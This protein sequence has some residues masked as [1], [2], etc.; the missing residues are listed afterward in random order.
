M[1]ASLALQFSLAIITALVTVSPLSASPECSDS[2]VRHMATHG[3]TVAA[4]GE[5]CAMDEDDVLYIIEA[6]TESDIG[7]KLE[8]GSELNH[9]KQL[10]ASGKPVGDCG[11]WG[12]VYPNYEQLHPR[13]Q[14]GVAVPRMCS[15]MCPAGGYAWQGVCK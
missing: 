6:G 8:P 5:T 12:F 3:E 10:L 1:N 14:S 7:P 2:K 4:I 9:T 15:S 13:C 11:C